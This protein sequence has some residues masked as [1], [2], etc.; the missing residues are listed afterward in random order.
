MKLKVGIHEKKSVGFANWLTF[1]RVWQCDYQLLQSA[2]DVTFSL[3][4]NISHLLKNV[5]NR[6][7]VF[8]GN[9]FF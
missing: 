7:S 1:G 5:K 8:T 2:I 9:L 6:C 3:Y 4:I